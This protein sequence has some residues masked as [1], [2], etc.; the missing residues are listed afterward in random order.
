MPNAGERYSF[1]AR[2]FTTT[3]TTPEEIHQI[4][5]KEVARIR[6]EMDQIIEQ[7][8]FRGSREEFFKVLRTDPQFYY[9]TPD[10]LFEAYQA[11]AKTVDPR[12]VKVFRTLPREPYGGEAIPAGAAP[13]TTA[14]YYRPGAPDGPRSGTYFVNLYKPETRPKCAI[15]ML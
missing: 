13:R 4:G 14:A 3:D 5:L 7:S 10:D 2:R 9:K 6:A 12:L 11:L 1:L 15:T 8:G